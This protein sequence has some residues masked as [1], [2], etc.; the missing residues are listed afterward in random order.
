[1]HR[2]G[3]EVILDVVYNHTAEGGEAGP[4]LGFKGIENG[5]YYLLEEDRSRYANYSGTGNT[6]NANH[7]VVRRLILDSLRFWV[8][9]MH[10]DG[11]RFDLASILARDT[12]GHVLPNPPVLWDIDTDPWLAGVKLIAEAWDAGG[13]YQVGH[14]VGDNWKEW[15]GR[16]R[17]DLR[18]FFRGERGAV[19]HIADRMLGSPDL[20]RHKEREAE[21]SV[22]FV[23]CHDGFTLDDL[24]SYNRK[25]NEANGEGNGDGSDDNRSWNCGVDGPSED[26]SVEALRS[27]QAR[28]F[29]SVTMLSLGVPMILMGDEM[30]RTQNGNNNAYCQDNETSWLD[31]GLLE[32][33]ADLH[34]FVRHLA[35]RRRRR[36]FGRDTQCLSEVIREADIVWHGVRCGQPD[37]SDDSHSLAFT[38]EL[39]HLNMRVHYLMNAWNDALEFELPCGDGGV[40]RRWIDTGLPSPDDI[41]PWEEAPVFAGRRYRLEGHA[42]AAL[43]AEIGT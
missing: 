5:A 34:R 4:T 19:R 39:R 42:V 33:H 6:L 10:V 37:W 17:D 43:F 2:A 14:F 11:F 7:P 22:N 27:R 30:R 20:Y 9:D 16:F 35:T 26:A 3:I 36:D 28:N 8:E 41:V 25:R 13:L 29:L 18:D 23:T 21:Q 12:T 31:W 32:K 15:N 38:A 40:W 1:M 24:V